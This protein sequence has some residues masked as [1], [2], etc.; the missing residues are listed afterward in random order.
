[1][2]VTLSLS[3]TSD[4]AYLPK[5]QISEMKSLASR[6]YALCCAAETQQNRDVSTSRPLRGKKAK[7][8]LPADEQLKLIAKRHKTMHYSGK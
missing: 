3:D 2:A 5:K 8:E 6:L 1:M 4:L 7:K